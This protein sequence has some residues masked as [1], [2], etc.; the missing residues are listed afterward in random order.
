LDKD[1]PSMPERTKD[2]RRKSLVVKRSVKI[3]GRRTSVALEAAFWDSLKSIAAAQGT[4]V[5]HER[6]PRAPDWEPGAAAAEIA[7]LAA[8]SEAA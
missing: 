3:G 8:A 2:P 5:S 1:Q 6:R 7:E 4:Q